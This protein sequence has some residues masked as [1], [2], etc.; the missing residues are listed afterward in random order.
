MIDKI[1]KKKDHKPNFSTPKN[2][3]RNILIAKT[4]RKVIPL[5]R[6]DQTVSLNSLFLSFVSS[7]LIILF[8]RA[9]RKI[10]HFI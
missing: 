9:C 1:A 7:L 5:V 10:I 8:S 3:A 6:K 2:L 4:K